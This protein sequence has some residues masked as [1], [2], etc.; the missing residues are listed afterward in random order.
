[1]PEVVPE[2]LGELARLAGAEGVVPDD[3]SGVDGIWTTTVPARERDDRDWRIAMNADTGQE[4]VATD[5]PNEG[6]ESSIPPGRAVVYLGGWPAGI[7]G[8]GG[9]EI[10]V[11]VL[12]D[13]PQ[14]MED[15]LIGD[16]QARKADLEEADSA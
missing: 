15:E 11:E 5:F 13:G 2:L 4:L 9:G 7:V 16:V 3:G 1:M 14:S 6:D 10:V 12:D 8:P